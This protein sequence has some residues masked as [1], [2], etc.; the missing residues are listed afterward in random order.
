[1]E[2]ANNLFNKKRDEMSNRLN[3]SKAVGAMARAAR[4]E[5]YGDELEE[6]EEA[7]EEEYDYFLDT[8]QDENAAASQGY[9]IIDENDLND[10]EED[11]GE[12]LDEDERKQR[13]REMLK[14]FKER[15]ERDDR[16]NNKK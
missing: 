8:V 7:K 3:E 14:E 13:H 1:M 12:D 4:D 11:E 10:E 5:L 2:L 9:H 6:R 15:M 16:K